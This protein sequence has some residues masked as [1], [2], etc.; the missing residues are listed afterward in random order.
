MV[1]LKTTWKKQA[2]QRLWVNEELLQKRVEKLLHVQPIK[3][4]KKSRQNKKEEKIALIATTHVSC[5]SL[6]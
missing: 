6:S 2:L 3:G 1:R 5:S 4:T